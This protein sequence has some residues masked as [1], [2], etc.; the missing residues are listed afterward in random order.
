VTVRLDSG[1]TPQPVPRQAESSK[2]KTSSVSQDSGG[3]IT[4]SRSGKKSPPASGLAGP[5]GSQVGVKW[6]HCVAR[7]PLA[8]RRRRLSHARRF[9]TAASRLASQSVL[10]C[11]RLLGTRL[12]ET[13]AGFRPLLTSHRSVHLW[14]ALPVHVNSTSCFASA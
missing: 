5:G 2:P 14:K 11:K 3:M 6:V 9:S 7:P 12:D 10:V 13:R 4:K 1:S 8:L